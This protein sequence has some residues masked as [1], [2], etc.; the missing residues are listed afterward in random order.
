M[1]RICDERL[2]DRKRR[3]AKMLSPGGAIAFSEHL[4]HDGAAVFAAS[5]LKAS[6]PSVSTRHI[7]AG[8]AQ[9]EK[10]AQ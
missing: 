8:L 3:P 7:A 10:P 6:F 5:A 2:I 4:E 1:A 9:V